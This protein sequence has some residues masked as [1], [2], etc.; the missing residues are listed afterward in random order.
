MDREELIKKLKELA[1]KNRDE[2][3][4]HVKADELLLQFIDDQEIADA[5][6]S[7]KKWYA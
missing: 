5:F 3:S 7:I 4:D 2:E 1:T 6:R